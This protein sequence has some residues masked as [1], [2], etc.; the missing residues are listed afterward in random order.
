MNAPRYF[1]IAATILVAIIALI[2]LFSH[3]DFNG[4]DN[5]RVGMPTTT[6]GVVHE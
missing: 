5:N 6:M 1:W 2:L 4:N 3:V